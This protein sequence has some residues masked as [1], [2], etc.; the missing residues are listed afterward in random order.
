M[1]LLHLLPSLSLLAAALVFVKGS[2]VEEISKRYSCCEP[3]I[4]YDADCENIWMINDGNFALSKTNDC[5][6][7]C[8]RIQDGVMTLSQCVAFDAIVVCKKQNVTT[9]QRFIFTP[10]TCARS[11]IA[12]GN[13]GS[14]GSVLLALLTGWFV[15]HIC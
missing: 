10:E 12:P 15:K 11:G 6:S 4:Q 13:H 5:A 9:E 3:K 8:V 2:A 1:K 14:V 7:P